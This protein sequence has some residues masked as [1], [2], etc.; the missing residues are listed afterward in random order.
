[1]DGWVGWVGK[2]AVSFPPGLVGGFGGGTEAV[3][4]WYFGV[5]EKAME[6]GRSPLYPY[7]SVSVCVNSHDLFF[8]LGN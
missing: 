6:R 2:S 7:V 1:V 3:R 4:R 5:R 8:T